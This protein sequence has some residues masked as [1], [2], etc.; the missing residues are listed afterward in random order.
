MLEHI[1]FEKALDVLAECRRV[2]KSGGVLR[3]IVFDGEPY[4]LEYANHVRGET[5]N[6]PHASSD[7]EDYADRKCQP[8]IPQSRALFHMGL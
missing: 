7:V 3:V 8:H 2:L 4:L 6:M 1:P 5:T